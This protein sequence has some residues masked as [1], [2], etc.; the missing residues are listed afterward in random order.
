MRCPLALVAL[1]LL[2][3]PAAAADDL[4]PLYP[5][6]TV[7]VF[8]ADI[9]QITKSPL[10]KKVIGDDKPFT[11]ARKLLGVLITEDT[12]K[13]PDAIQRHF[14]DLANKLERVTVVVTMKPKGGA[15]VAVILDGPNTEADYAKAL[16]A[17]AKEEGSAFKIEN[18]GGRKRM[19]FTA[20]GSQQHAASVS[21]SR[22]VF[23]DSSDLID[24]VLNKADG[25]AKAFENKALN[26]A[27]K[28]ITPAETP[29]WFVLAT[30]ELGAGS[31]TLGLKDDADFR[32][33]FTSDKYAELVADVLKSAFDEVARR[34]TPQ[35]KVWTAAKIAVKRD[36]NTV[37]AAGTFPG[38]LLAEEYAKQK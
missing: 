30:S 20:G 31:I 34:D 2:A 4:P 35:G 13:F 21:K 24:D 3:A 17:Y 27:V 16:E 7:A 38:K 10:G 37:T 28:R 29:V 5:D 25:K 33:E 19:T 12:I 6:D 1:A 36:G 18:R 32:L 11:A 14:A 15:G 22:F 9:S 26:A 8:T 23:G